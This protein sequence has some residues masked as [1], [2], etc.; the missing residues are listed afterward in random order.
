MVGGVRQLD[1]SAP[2]AQYRTCGVGFGGSIAGPPIMTPASFRLCCTA[3]STRR[4]CGMR[5]S[6]SRAPAGSW[7]SGVAPDDC[8]P[9]SSLPPRAAVTRA[10]SALAEGRRAV[11][12]AVLPQRPHRVAPLERSRSTAGL[13][14][15]AWGG[16]RPVAAARR[17]GHRHGGGDAR[18]VVPGPWRE[19]RV[20]R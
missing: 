11:V 7:T 15:A 17:I 8:P 19:P 18:R 16:E 10:G 9:G 4:Y 1:L 20:M 5:G 3:R 2:G 12:P 14:M 13:P 6:I